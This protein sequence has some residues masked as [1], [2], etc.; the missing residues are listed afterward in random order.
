MKD[1]RGEDKPQLAALP[2]PGMRAYTKC[3]GTSPKNGTC[4]R[5]NKKKKGSEPKFAALD[6]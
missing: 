3:Q 6:F 5:L 2:S 4:E 1:L